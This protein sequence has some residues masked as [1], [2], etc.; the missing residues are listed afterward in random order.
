MA[1]EIVEAGKDFWNI[2]GDLRIAGIVNIGTQCSLVRLSEDRFIFLDS[3]TLTGDIRE[4]VMALTDQGRKV[5]AV[6]NV[7]PFHT[8]HCARMAKDFPGAT[9]HGSSRHVRVVPQVAWSPEAVESE[10]VADRYPQLAFSLPDGIDYISKDEN[11]H[12]G[13]LLVFHGSSGTLHV[14]DT[15]NVLPG[16]IRKVLPVPQ[17]AFHPMLKAALHDTPDAGARFCNWADRIATE[18]SG[19]RTLCA[20]HSALSRFDEGEFSKA[21]RA[22]TR[23]ARA[24]LTG[25]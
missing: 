16:L 6:L 12:A 8:L 20:A 19:T 23:K 18:W 9:F 4:R 15:F 10:A 11:V 22:T 2:R 7:H 14:D 5:E 21:L 1:E 24:K 3:Y 17:I 25:A 13:S